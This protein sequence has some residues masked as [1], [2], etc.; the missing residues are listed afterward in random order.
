MAMIGI[1]VM[2]CENDLKEVERVSQFETLP[3]N[4][5]YNSHIEYT[6]SGRVMMI[7]EAGQIDRYQGEEPQDEF[8]K[9]IRVLSYNSAGELESE[10]TAENAT[11]YPEKKIMEARD[12]V[13]LMDNEGKRLDTE[14]LTW[15]E[16]TGKIYT[17]K[18]VQ[19]S[20][21]TEI[22]YGDGLKAK[23]D[24]S[25]YEITNIKG[26]I[27]VEEGNNDTTKVR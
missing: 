2:G 14:L 26:R 27:K 4:T 6:D 5:I 23:Q 15:D 18:F 25:S 3:L 21:P 17:D 11:N 16:N 7:I 19:I 9:G 12:S 24:F 10:I 8:S 13:V 1:V 20:T 22:L